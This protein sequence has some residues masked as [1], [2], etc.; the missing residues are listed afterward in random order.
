MYDSELAMLLDGRKL[1]RSIGYDPTSGS[2]HFNLRRNDLTSPFQG[3]NLTTQ[4]GPL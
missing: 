3:Y 4:S 1:R 2:T